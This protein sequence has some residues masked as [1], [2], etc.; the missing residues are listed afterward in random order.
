MSIL[1]CQNERCSTPPKK[2][3]SILAGASK[4]AER[5]G[6]TGGREISQQTII[7]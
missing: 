4:N 7:A 6:G 2:I 3:N 5:P 1:A